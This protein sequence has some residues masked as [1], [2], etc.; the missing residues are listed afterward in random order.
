MTEYLTGGNYFKTETR[1]QNLARARV[2]LVM[3]LQMQKSYPD[4]VAIVKKYL[5]G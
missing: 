4:M 5:R 1:K 2:Q 3:C